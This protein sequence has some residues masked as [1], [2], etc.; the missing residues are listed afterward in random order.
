MTGPVIFDLRLTGERRTFSVDVELASRARSIGIFG[1]SGSGKTTL[2]RG[3]AGLEPEF[4]GHVRIQGETLFDTAKVR[5]PVHERRIGFVFQES[6]LFPH[7]T[8]S[9][10]LD[11]GR[12]GPDD[13][14]RRS[15]I[16]LLELEPLL[17]ARPRTLSGGES[18]RVAIG[19]ALLTSPRVLV[20][21][22]PFAGLDDRRKRQIE[23]FLAR[24]RDELEIPTIVVSHDTAELAGLVDEY[25]V[26]DC[27][28]IAAHGSPFDCAA[29]IAKLTRSPAINAWRS[30]WSDDGWSGP[31]GWPSS[32]SVRATANH[33]SGDRPA[34]SVACLRATDAWISAAA[35]T[36]PR[37]SDGVNGLPDDIVQW[38]GTIRRSQQ[39][40]SERTLLEIA[41]TTEADPILVEANAKTDWNVGVGVTLR[42]RSSS[43]ELRPLHPRPLTSA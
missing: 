32:A 33:S 19:R 10:N 30:T 23:P 3:L 15:I 20:L 9:E 13:V 35:P 22:E 42:F 36:A 2:L 21:D 24:M 8:V 14:T 17:S 41:P 4:E 29:D 28:R 12:R 43:V 11:F 7:L 40:D 18:R 26:M 16:E 37:T 27:G 34:T 6:R 25:V 5:V 31:Y 1:A 38:T 39:L